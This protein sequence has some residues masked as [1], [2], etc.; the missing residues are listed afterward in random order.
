MKTTI[1]SLK[2]VIRKEVRMY[3]NEGREKLSLDSVIK[4]LNSIRSGRSL[5]DQDIMVEM[6]KYY[7]GLDDAEKKALQSFLTGIS[8]IVTGNIEG[9]SAAEPSEDPTNIKMIDKKNI[10][11]KSIKPNVIHKNGS[12]QKNQPPQEDIAPPIS[13]K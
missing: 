3:L 4:T 13:V 9:E 12:S 5:K 6:E 7:N 8:Q 10:S 2:E 1:N 11:S